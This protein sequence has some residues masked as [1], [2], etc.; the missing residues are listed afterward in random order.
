MAPP[1]QVPPF[2]PRELILR[3]TPEQRFE[4]WKLWEGAFIRCN[5]TYFH[6]DGAERSFWNVLFGRRR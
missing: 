4:L 3:C 2:P 6:S 5:P 1:V